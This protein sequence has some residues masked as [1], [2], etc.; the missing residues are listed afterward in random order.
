MEHSACPLVG[1]NAAMMHVSGDG[2]CMAGKT[3]RNHRP[4][5]R[6]NDTPRTHVDVRRPTRRNASRRTPTQ[7]AAQCQNH[8]PPTTRLQ[9]SILDGNSMH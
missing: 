5:C 1:A 2:S 6:V 8:M 3:Q 9:Y 7:D 4:M